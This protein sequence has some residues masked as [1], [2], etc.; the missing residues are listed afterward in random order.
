[1]NLATLVEQ[2]ATTAEQAAVLQGDWRVFRSRHGHGAVCYRFHFGTALSPGDPLCRSEDAAS[3]LGEF[4]DTCRRRRWHAVFVPAN[5]SFAMA[6]ASAG[7]AGWKV[8]EG[9]LI[10]L[11]GW[12][13][14]GKAGARLRGDLGHA[15]RYGV[16]TAEW[17]RGE[18][19]AVSADQ[20][21]SVWRAWRGRRSAV[22]LGFV[23]GGDVLA[24]QRLRRWF[25]ARC[26]DEVQAFAV[27]VSLPARNAI[28][29]EH[30]VRRPGAIRGSVEAAIVGALEQHRQEGGKLGLLAMAPLRGIAPGDTNRPS[31]LGRRDRSHG[32]ALMAER[33]LRRNG[34]AL[35]PARTLESFK[36]KFHPSAW[37]PLYLVHYPARLLPRMALAAALEL[38]PG[39]PGAWGRYAVRAA[40]G[41]LA[42]R[43]RGG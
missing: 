10:E 30:F 22:P 5:R 7:C 36:A 42:G 34:A 2:F 28:A 33:M 38:L 40:A 26:N 32:V 18:A 27:T 9:P 16:D 35:Y 12:S 41:T 13:H 17:R 14:A 3:L 37:E 19:G 25:V 31:L 39:G 21:G 1:M 20:L 29:V 23:L 11:D 24:E 15:R 4:L 6:A 43:A 8:G